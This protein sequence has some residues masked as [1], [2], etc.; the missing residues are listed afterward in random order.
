MYRGEVCEDCG[1]PVAF[2]VSSYW[3]APDELWLAVMGT[4]AG[5]LCPPCFTGRARDQGKYVSW[6]AEIEESG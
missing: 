3:T 4:D 1:F 6:R 2:F 5:I